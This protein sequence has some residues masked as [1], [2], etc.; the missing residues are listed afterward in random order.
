MELFKISKLQEHYRNPKNA[1]CMEDADGRGRSI[2]PVSGD[3]IEISLKIEAGWIVDAKFKSFGAPVVIAVSSL[4]TETIKGRSVE[5]A[6][7]LSSEV[8]DGL[9]G[10]LQ[11]EDL[12]SLALAAEALIGAIEDYHSGNE[13]MRKAVGGRGY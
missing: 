6:L 10:E 4:L 12:Y 7:A 9:T 11:Q 8:L 5:E 2:N 13:G 3:V 1:G